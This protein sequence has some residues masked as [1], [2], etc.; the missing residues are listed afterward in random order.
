MKKI[1][2]IFTM[3][4]SLV[5]VL[6]SCEDVKY[7][8]TPYSIPVSNYNYAIEGRALTLTWTLPDGATQAAVLKD[9][10][11]IVAVEGNTY[12]IANADDNQEHLYTV[13]A[14]YDNGRVSE[15][16][17][18]AITV[19]SKLKVG[20]YL[21]VQNYTD[22][23]D[24]DEVAAAE[25][26]KA[27]YVDAETGVFVHSSDLSSLSPDEVSMIWIQIDRIGLGHGNLP[28]SSSDVAA[29]K[30]YVQDGGKLFLTKQA[31]QLVSFI[32]RIDAQY[33]PGIYGDGEGGTG[34]D[35]W[36]MNSVIGCKMDAAYDHRDHAAFV[37]LEAGDPN[38]YGFETY[39]MEGPGLRED[40]NCM[41]DLNAYGFSGQPNVVANWQDATNSTVLTTWGH[42][43][44]Y[45]CAGV[46]EFHPTTD[47][48][49]SIIACGLSTYEFRQ[50]APQEGTQ[51]AYQGNIERFTKNC[52]DYL[53]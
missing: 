7:D 53:K 17:T 29:L 22:L 43:A 13:K 49:G 42:V 21:T 52:I 3:M 37:G 30:A 27:Q 32:G 11:Q 10:V 24:D 4:L 19:E 5:A 41:W 20:Y 50:N 40:H 25:W 48:A 18:I 14:I 12:T 33:A 51:N 16:V 9:G 23:P 31:T 8:N 36:C 34:T 1:S 39:P 35:V 6:T 26:F 44:D 15:G 46:I 45:C 47:F 38:G 2:F 28:L